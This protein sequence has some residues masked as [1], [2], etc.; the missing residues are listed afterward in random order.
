MPISAS[1]TSTPLT[2]TLTGTVEL[3]DGVELDGD[4]NANIANGRRFLRWAGVPLP[5]GT[6]LQAISAK[7]GVHWD[8]TTLTFDDGSFTVDGNAADGLLAVTTGAPPRIEGTLAFDRLVLDPYLARGNADEQADSSGLFDWALL[9]YLDADLRISAGEI[10]AFA[11]DTG[12]ALGL[13]NRFHYYEL[14][15]EDELGVLL[16]EFPQPWV[17]WQFDVGHLQVHAALGLMDFRRWVERFG[18]RIVGIHLHDVQGIVDHRAP[19]SGDV[20]FALVAAHLPAHAQRTLEVDKSLTLEEVRA[21]MEYL[22][23][24]GCVTRL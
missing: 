12:L 14:P 2:A 19:G 20:D 24:A 11:Q 17:G 21:G 8:G 6:S 15:I 9:R 3:G 4:M 13:E 18:S 1:F 23:R 7:G 22:V 16:Q 10:V 5:K